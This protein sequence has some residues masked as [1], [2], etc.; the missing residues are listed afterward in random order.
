MRSTRV[1]T[2]LVLALGLIVGW[3]RPAAAVLVQGRFG[4]F[5]VSGSGSPVSP[6]NLSGTLSYDTAAATVESLTSTTGRYLF[7]APGSAT[8]AVTYTNPT[9]GAPLASFAVAAPSVEIGVQG[10]LD[11]RGFPNDTIFHMTATSPQAVLEIDID[12]IISGTLVLPDGGLPTASFPAGFDAEFIATDFS[13]PSRPVRLPPALLFGDLA[14][15]T[16]PEPPALAAVG[17]G[18]GLFVL[19]RRRAYPRSIGNVSSFAHS[20][21]EPS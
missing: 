5:V 9:T 14:L 8:L 3:A 16:V 1:L 7:S 6:S 19:L 18:V 20:P 10:G 15:A 21:I 11:A 4:G 2:W 17:L 12:D 13:D